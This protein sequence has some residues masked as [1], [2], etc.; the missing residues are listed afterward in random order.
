[1]MKWS[2][3]TRRAWYLGL[4]EARRAREKATNPLTPRAMV[5]KALLLALPQSSSTMARHP[6][7]THKEI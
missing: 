3:E 2:A 5:R 6:E 1:M 7:T 4:I